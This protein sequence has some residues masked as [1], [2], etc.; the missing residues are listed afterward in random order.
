MLRPSPT[1]GHY[2]CPMMMM[3]Q[4]DWLTNGVA[5]NRGDTANCRGNHFPHLPRR[6][7]SRLVAPLYKQQQNDEL[8]LQ[9]IIE[10]KLSNT[11]EGHVLQIKV[12]ANERLG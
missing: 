2:G 11:F 4:V 12:A 5:D 8:F 3:K 7:L 1:T 6:H 10:L 9:G